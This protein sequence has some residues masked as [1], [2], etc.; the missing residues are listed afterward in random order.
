MIHLEESCKDQ[1][2]SLDMR[3]ELQMIKL[4]M[5]ATKLNAEGTVQRKTNKSKLT[6]VEITQ[7]SG[8]TTDW[9]QY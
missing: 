1:E 2:E 3:E 9:P 5:Q 8:M 4:Q 7:F 6:R